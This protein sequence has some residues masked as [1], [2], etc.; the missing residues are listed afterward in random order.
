MNSASFGWT[1]IVRLGLV[2]TMLGAIIVLMTSTINRVMVVELALPAVV[3]GLLVASHY[4]IQILRPAWGYGSDVGGR[5]TPWIIGGMAALA[6]GGIGAALGTALAAS[7]RPL[8]V[9]VAALS[10]LLL[11]IGAGSAGTSVLAMLATHVEPRRRAFAASAVWMMMILGFAISAPLAGSFLDPFSNTR[12]IAVTSTI[13]A[14]AFTV[15][16]PRC[17]GRRNGSRGRSELGSRTAAKP[18]FRQA[19]AE[20]WREPAARRFTIFIFVSMLAYGA[21][22]LLVEPFAGLV[23]GMSPGSTTKLAGLQHGGVFVGMVG[24]AILAS[25]IGGRYSGFSADV[26]DRRVCLLGA[27]AFGNRGR[28]LSIARP[29]RVPGRR[30]RTGRFERRL[31]RRS[32]WLDDGARRDG[33]GLPRG[34]ADGSLGRGA[35]HCVRARRRSG[36]PVG[37]SCARVRSV[38]AGRLCLGLR[39]GIRTLHR[40]GDPRIP[41]WPQ[42]L[43]GSECAGAA[44]RR[45]PSDHEEGRPMI[46]HEEIFDFVV[47]GGGPAGATAADDLA[48]RGR[49]VALLDR[50][51]RIK[52]C[53]G[54]IPPRLIRDFA[55]PS[56]LLKARVRLATMI[57]P[58]GQSV[59]MPIDG[60]GF[61][62]M[63]DRN[64]FDEW[65]R[66]RAAKSGATRFVGR[67]EK[68]TRNGDGVVRV[69]FA[70]KAGASEQIL[71]TRFVIGADGAN[72]DGRPAGSAGRDPRPLRFRL[73]RDHRDPGRRGEAIGRI[74]LRDPLPGNA[75]A[76]F[77]RMDLP[78]WRH[79]ERRLRQRE[80]GLFA[81]DVRWRRCVR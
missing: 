35:G 60:G 24:V 15:A 10:F 46:D 45:S 77:L 36:H 51:G 13:C 75:V 25:V 79:D 33:R 65:L 49:K 76:R 6:L 22:E 27:V 55:I 40:S 68:I 59:D 38:P 26:D 31:R 52:P 58:K 20:V 8:G 64:S 14:I 66:D 78:A 34:H 71:K 74:S 3:P 62:G 72:S 73:P 53:G 44:G 57:S 17:L 32:H 21:Q 39:A 42:R 5:R 4:A 18:P 23:F 50:S 12:L 9:S 29:R 61:V 54:A 2:Q 80:K 67:Y 41:G 16:Y 69:H 28:R 19:L 37:R 63:V 70:P 30:L 11:G 81:E 56:H 1:K 7:S 48:S 47:V 43:Q